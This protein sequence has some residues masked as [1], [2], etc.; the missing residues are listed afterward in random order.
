MAHMDILRS[1][2]NC[3]ADISNWIILYVRHGASD[4]F[5]L[6]KLGDPAVPTCS[7]ESL[8]HARDA[9]TT[10]HQNQLVQLRQRGIR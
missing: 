10:A 1:N 2:L 8:L 7:A 5:L 9:A 3:G 4:R 6:D